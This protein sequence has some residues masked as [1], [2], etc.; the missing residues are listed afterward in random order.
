MAKQMMQANEIISLLCDDEAAKKGLHVQMLTLKKG[1]DD[2]ANDAKAIER[3]F[4]QWL[5]MAYELE[6]TAEDQ[7]GVSNRCRLR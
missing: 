5:E 1:A 2:C 6:E 7:A 3:K 4:E